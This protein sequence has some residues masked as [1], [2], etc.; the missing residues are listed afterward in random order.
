MLDF[1]V[2][3]WKKL[4]DNEQEEFRSHIQSFIRL[5]GYI[6]QIVSFKDISLEKLFIFLRFLNKKLPKRTLGKLTDVGSSVDLES[7]RLEK[8]TEGSIIVDP[9]PYIEPIGGGG[10]GSVS[11]Y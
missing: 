8:K 3:D 6:T 2:E 1:T 7:F 5:Y 10:G 11:Y 9:N 4:E